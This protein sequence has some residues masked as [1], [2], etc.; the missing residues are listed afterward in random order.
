VDK[1]Y[2][3]CAIIVSLITYGFWDEILS[4]Y[5]IPIFYIGNALFIFM[6]CG[7]IYYKDKQ[8]FVKFFLFDIALSNLVDEL[9]FDNTK[10]SV[11]ELLLFLIIP[12]FWYLKTKKGK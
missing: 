5:K 11:C 6:I 4:A 12:I 7:Y 9:F 2:L 3:W 8:S 1:V 10:M